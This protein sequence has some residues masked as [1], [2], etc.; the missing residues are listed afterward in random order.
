MAKKVENNINVAV[1]R[2]NEFKGKQTSKKVQLL[3][4]ATVNVNGVVVTGIKFMEGNRGYF[5]SMPSEKSGDEYYNTIWLDLGSKEENAKGYDL[6]LKA[7]VAEY[8]G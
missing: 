3:G 1:V 2:F 4:F 5:M 7:I 8:E 6:I